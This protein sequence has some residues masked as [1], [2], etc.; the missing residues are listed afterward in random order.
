MLNT[1]ITAPHFAHLPRGDTFFGCKY[2][3]IFEIMQIILKFF[4]KNLQKIA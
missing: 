2:S 3:H 1:A 4:L